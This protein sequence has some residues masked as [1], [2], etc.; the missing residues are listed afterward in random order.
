MKINIVYLSFKVIKV[1]DRKV[2]FVIC[3]SDYVRFK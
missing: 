1:G 3:F 2:V